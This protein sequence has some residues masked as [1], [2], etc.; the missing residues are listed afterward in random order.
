MTM[1]KTSLDPCN[2]EH[3]KKTKKYL[4]LISIKLSLKNFNMSKEEA[5]LRINN[6]NN[7]AE[8]LVFNCFTL[9]DTT[10]ELISINLSF[11]TKR[12]CHSL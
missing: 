4:I 1:S 8:N 6:K 2:Y 11:V 3:H 7:N 12:W 5:F 10:I 9:Y